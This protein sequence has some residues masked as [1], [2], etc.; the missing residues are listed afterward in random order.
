MNK[1][2]VVLVIM[3][4]SVC[5]FANAAPVTLTFDDLPDT[6]TGA[7]VPNGYGGLN[8]GFVGYSADF[9]D[10][11]NQA[12]GYGVLMFVTSQKGEFDF[13]SADFA[14]MFY[15]PITIQAIGLNFD[16]NGG[17]HNMVTASR[18][19]NY[20]DGLKT[21][22]F[23]FD[24]IDLLIFTALYTDED[25]LRYWAPFDMDNF[26]YELAA[27]PIPASLLLLGSALLGLIGFR[28]AIHQ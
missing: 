11:G 13:V 3:F 4:M 21:L 22:T 23:D 16:A 17:L 14:S 6:E 26:T 24:N 15:D 2:A 1:R 19:L 9:P 10:Q 18:S 12:W 5:G 25:M 7:P 8:W 20:D 28:R 27:I